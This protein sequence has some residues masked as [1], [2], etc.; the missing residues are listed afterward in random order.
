MSFHF[1]CHS[2]VDR[3]ATIMGPKE[4]EATKQLTLYAWSDAVVFELCTIIPEGSPQRWFRDMW[5]V[6]KI[7]GL[8]VFLIKKNICYAPNQC[9]LKGLTKK[10][11]EKVFKKQ[12]SES[13]PYL[14]DVTPLVSV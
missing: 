2:A 8:F 6:Q 14:K 9:S 7:P 10:I 1:L 11:L 5:L 13:C 12:N 4:S 3:G